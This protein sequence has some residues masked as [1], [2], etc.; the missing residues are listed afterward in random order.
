MGSRAL[1]DV[2]SNYFGLDDKQIM[3]LKKLNSKWVTIIK[4]FPMI[5]LSE[6]MAYVL[7]SSDD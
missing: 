6:H 5:V 1:K 7:N 4:D 3:K 2:L